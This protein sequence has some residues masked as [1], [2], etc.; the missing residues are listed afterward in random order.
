MRVYI[1]I[2]NYGKSAPFYSSIGIALKLILVQF[3]R[4]SSGN[5][6][7]DT[8]SSQYQNFK[9]TNEKPRITKSA[10]LVGIELEE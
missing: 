6:Q 9:T 1:F 10:V 2:Y 4:F 8:G 5:F 3:F 7:F